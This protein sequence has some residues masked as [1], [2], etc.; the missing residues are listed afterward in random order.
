MGNMKGRHRSGD[1]GIDVKITLNW[2]FNRM[3]GY[4]LA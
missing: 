2:I 3:R 4:E 1:L